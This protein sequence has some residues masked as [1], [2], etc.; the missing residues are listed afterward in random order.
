MELAAMRVPLLNASVG[1]GDVVSTC[2]SNDS[3][4]CI[5]LVISWNDTTC[6]CKDIDKFRKTSVASDGSLKKSMMR[7]KDCKKRITIK[8]ITSF[9][10][11]F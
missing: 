2:P 9:N 7:I 5:S 1:K 6:G 11:A 8:H 4:C 3:H 10:P